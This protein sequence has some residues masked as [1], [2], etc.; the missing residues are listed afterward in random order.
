MKKVS[1][2]DKSKYL[3]RPAQ[4]ENEVFVLIRVH[5]WLFLFTLFLAA[6]GKV[7]DPLP[8]I[9]RAPLTVD[10]LTATQQGDKIILSFPLNRTVRSI[11][12]QRIDVYR[13]LESV[14]EPEGM[15][16]ETFSARAGVIASIPADQIPVGTSTIGYTDAIDFQSAGQPRYRYAVRLVNQ[17]NRAAPFSNYALVSPLLEIS[18]P[19]ANLQTRLTQTELEITWTPPAANLSGRQPANTAGYNIYR[20]VAGA[21]IKLNAKPL[22]E[23]RYV[24][25]AFQFETPYEYAVRALSLPAG[26]TDLNDALES[27]ESVAIAITPKDTFPPSAPDSITIASVNSIVSLFWPANA[28]PDTAGYNIYR[29]DSA[30]TPPAQWVRLNS[31][32]HKPTSFRDERV[33][34]GKEYFYQITA[35]D[36]N[37]NESVRSETKAEVV[38]P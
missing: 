38:N 33:Q 9:P 18:A 10:S 7:G 12:P 17:D 20:R 34:V 23:P 24:D 21:S 27:N 14:S 8:P 6:C 25:R 3:I 5:S 35:V 26:K 1:V 11:L 16:E 15:T 29:A 31:Q 37:G 30:D 4:P 36:N 2:N 28:E 22:T 32:L 19:P 13:L